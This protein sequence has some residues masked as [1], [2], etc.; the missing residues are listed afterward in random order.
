M[1]TK[2]NQEHLL[3]SL[4]RKGLADL[5]QG[6]GKCR[7]C[8][9][10]YWDGGQAYCHQ[11]GNRSSC[12]DGI[13]KWLGMLQVPGRDHYV[14]TGSQCLYDVPHGKIWSFTTC[15]PG[16]PDTTGNTWGKRNGRPPFLMPARTGA[17]PIAPMT[18]GCHGSM[19]TISPNPTADT[20]RPSYWKS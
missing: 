15:S 4:D 8:T 20:R 7:C 6:H 5:I 11:N 18:P 10:Y 9:N 12:E 16:W 2:T 19:H 14:P 3:E 13:A 1:T 17:I